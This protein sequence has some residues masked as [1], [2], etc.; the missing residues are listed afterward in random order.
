ML[1]LHSFVLA[2][3]LVSPT[4]TSE[5]SSYLGARQT[6]KNHFLAE[7]FDQAARGFEALWE[8]YQRLPDLYAAGLARYRL[9]HNAHAI[10]YWEHFLDLA[11]TTGLEDPKVERTKPQLDDARDRVSPQQLIIEAPGPPTSAVIVLQSEDETRP[12]L[13]REIEIGE[14][15]NTIPLKLD[16]GSWEISV[17]IDGRTESVQIQLPSNFPAILVFSE[18]TILPSPIRKRLS[19]GLSIPGLTLAG[20]GAGI[21]FITQYGRYKRAKNP[22]CD[23]T[24]RDCAEEFQASLR[25]RDLGAH[26]MGGGA[27][28]LLSGLTTL[29]SKAK[30]RRLAWIT[31]IAIGGSFAAAGTTL[32]FTLKKK[33][34]TLLKVT[35]NEEDTYCER[36]K[37]GDSESTVWDSKYVKALS[38]RGRVHLANSILLGTGAGLLTGATIGLLVQRPYLRKQTREKL[39][40]FSLT[41]SL[42]S[43]NTGFLVSGAF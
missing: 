22:T 11:T 31:Q 36:P 5:K 27:G 39:S 16:R 41:P 4:E 26:A 10:D 12:P 33:T 34:T 37:I 42:S 40:R 43:Q 1:T 6:A 30:S 29:A 32:Y 28:F 17:N 13:T 21:L 2:M 9:E 19:L 14:G 8:K 3:M 25:L 35:C 24:L 23:N 18:Q 38:Q 7:R 20:A 15:E